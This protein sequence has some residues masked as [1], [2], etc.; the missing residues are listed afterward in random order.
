MFAALVLC[1]IWVI[2]LA[3]PISNVLAVIVGVV[4]ISIT[5]LPSMFL[6]VI[7]LACFFVYDIF[8]VFLSGK[9]FG[10]SVMVSVAQGLVPDSD[11][12]FPALITFHTFLSGGNSSMLGLGDIMIPGFFLCFL[13]R[14]DIIKQSLVE[15]TAKGVSPAQLEEGAGEGTEAAPLMKKRFAQ[16]KRK[17]IDSLKTIGVDADSINLTKGYFLP[18]LCMYFLGIFITFVMLVLTESGQP[19]LL[20][21]VPCVLIYPLIQGYRRGELKSLWKGAFE[22]PKGVD[23]EE[24]SQT[25]A[26][27]QK[28]PEDG[29]PNKIEL[30]RGTIEGI[31][32][33]SDDEDNIDVAAA[34]TTTTNPAKSTEEKDKEKDNDKDKDAADKPQAPI[35]SNASS[36]AAAAPTFVLTDDN[37]DDDND[38]IDTA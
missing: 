13:Y 14:A 37:D 28:P 12:A 11:T 1:L 20:Y 30:T 22:I 15:A 17:V 27:Q 34:T 33:D 25:F 23:A 10:T 8:W 36:S 32:S 19:A 3:Y 29:A 31:E 38:L 26:Q 7:V 6:C 35:D 21:L 5:Q 24:I 9:V 4:C 18:T 16:V 2:T